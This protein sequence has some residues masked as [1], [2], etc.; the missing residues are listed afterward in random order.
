MKP[1]WKHLVDWEG[2][3][4][5]EAKAQVK[6]ATGINVSRLKAINDAVSIGAMSIEQSQRL[7]NPDM[8]EEELE[9]MYIRTLVEKGIPITLEQSAKYNNR[10]LEEEIEIQRQNRQQRIN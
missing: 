9:I 7:L 2:L 4:E 6:E 5:E 8:S 1:E 3:T 10:T